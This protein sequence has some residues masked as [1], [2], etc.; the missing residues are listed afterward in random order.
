MLT[1]RRFAQVVA[2]MFAAVPGLS[3]LT[4][5][6]WSHSD[7]RYTWPVR[8]PWRLRIYDHGGPPMQF[9]VYINGQP[10]KRSEIIVQEYDQVKFVVTGGGG[11]LG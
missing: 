1:R 3:R 7:P 11:R 4:L 8:G 10:V 2:G 9:T 5:T 6:T